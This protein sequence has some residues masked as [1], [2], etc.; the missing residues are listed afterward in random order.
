MGEVRRD[1]RKIDWSTGKCPTIAGS[2]GR[3]SQC[4]HFGVAARRPGRQSGLNRSVTR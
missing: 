4:R 2:D 3:R 1:D